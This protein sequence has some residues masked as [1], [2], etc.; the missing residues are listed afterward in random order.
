M[1]KRPA[2][3]FAYH[4]FGLNHSF[5]I[6]LSHSSLSH[7]EHEPFTAPKRGKHFGEFFFGNYAS[8]R[9]IVLMKG[10]LLFPAEFV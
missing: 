5:V 7:L 2:R 3:A 8:A 10:I 4:A 9:L 1:L 6:Q